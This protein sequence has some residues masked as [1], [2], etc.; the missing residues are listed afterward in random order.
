MVHTLDSYQA[1]LFYII[2]YIL[3]NLNAFMIIIAMGFNLYLYYTN[4]AEFNQLPEKNN[5]AIQLISQVKGYFAIN[6][7]LALC[8][9]VTM[10]S[11]I[12]LPP[13]VGFFGKLMVLTT[14]LD[15]GKILL[16]F[17]A[18]FTS[19]IGA[20]YYLSVIKTLYFEETLYKKSYVLSQ[21]SLSNHFSI[22]LSILNLT[23]I[24]FIL[25]PSELLN[26]CDI[27]SLVTCS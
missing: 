15:N 3:T 16:V 22:V 6:P 12:G 10:F 18:V 8:L 17:V 23:M 14:A 4:S 25:V 20:V 11:F 7:S 1:F 19:V 2:Q 5:S 13:L 9:V 26:L 21:I 27:L 24:F